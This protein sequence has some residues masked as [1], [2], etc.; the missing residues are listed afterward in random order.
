[1]I[2]S[3]IKTAFELQ[4]DDLSELSDSEAYTLMNKVYRKILSFKDWSFLHSIYSGTISGTDLT[5]PADFD[6]L[7]DNFNYAGDLDYNVGSYVFVG[8]ARSPYKIIKIGERNKYRDSSGYCYVDYKN[9]KIVFTKAPGDVAAE[10]DYKYVP[11]DITSSTSPVIPARFHSVFQH[12]MAMEDFIIQQSPKAKSYA[13]ENKGMFDSL[14]ED[15]AIW[16]TKQ[17]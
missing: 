13:G 1:M 15:I 6:Q 9:N 3:A 2:G 7:L 8:T 12:G 17:I 16:D 10:F 14:V 5:L 11:D 4:V